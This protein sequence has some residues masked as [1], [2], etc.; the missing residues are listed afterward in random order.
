MKRWLI[1][2]T[3]IGLGA[4]LAANLSD[5]I[6]RPEAAS[7]IQKDLLAPA[8]AYKM[9]AGCITTDR[10]AIERGAYI[11]HNLNGDK[12][13]G[14]LPAGLSKKNPDGT[15]K[16]YGN[17]VACHNIEG[18]KGAGNIGP[19]LT[20]YHEF[21]IKTGTRDNAFVYQKIADARVDNPQTHMTINLT[22]GLFTER[23]ICDIT[24]YI[25]SIKH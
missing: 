17:C 10:D 8:K 23:E 3:T 7:I 25:V 1:L 2:S 16:Q 22:T 20:N 19:D 12:A 13:K 5:A 11:F 15:P 21:F 24:S 9:P 14:E 18:A 4:A 6:E